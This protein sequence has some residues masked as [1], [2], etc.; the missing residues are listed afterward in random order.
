MTKALFSFPRDH[1][2]RE[3]FFV[4]ESF[5]HKARTN[6]YW[7]ASL[8]DAYTERDTLVLDPMSGPGPILMASL[9]GRITLSGDIEPYWC[10]IQHQNIERI[11]TQMMFT[12]PAQCYQWDAA[13]LPFSDQSIPAI[14]TSPPYFDLFSNWNRTS[15]HD[16][17]GRHIGPSGQCYG[18]HEW[19]VGNIHI[20]ENYLAAMR[21]IYLE[22]RRV[23]KPSGRLIVIIG[24]KVRRRSIVP[25]TADTET[26]LLANGFIP[27]ARHDRQA[28]P[29]QFRNIHAARNGD[30][31]PLVDIE[32]ALV[33]DSVQFPQTFDAFK[34]HWSVIEAPSNG[35][36]PGRQLFNKQL[37]YAEAHGGNGTLILTNAGLMDGHG[38]NIVWRGDHLYKARARREWA[39]GVV[40]DMVNNYSL[41]AG[42][43]VALH[44][45]DRYARYL[46]QRLNTLG[47][48]ASIIASHCNLGQKL[49]W[50]TKCLHSDH[51]SQG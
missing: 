51:C 35:S 23:L 26:L 11:H 22:C 19:Q 24:D 50:Y 14:I 29:S 15:G 46:Q 4:Q 41:R 43:I 7:L 13:R 47:A 28:I 37:K 44:V 25:V 36:R 20:Y 45:T 42:D 3:R 1:H 5:Q 27:I 21:K 38:P 10:Q 39:F 9:K 18:F 49:A 40:A 8:L 6:L 2:L 32:T 16:L 31:Y 30:E 12:A 33:L 17:D 34:F 48:R